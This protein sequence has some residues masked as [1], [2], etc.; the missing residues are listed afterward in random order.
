MQKIK[1]IGRN[2]KVYVEIYK[3]DIR[4]DLYIRIGEINLWKRTK[5]YI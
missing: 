5:K 3:Y 1:N 4:K 2:L